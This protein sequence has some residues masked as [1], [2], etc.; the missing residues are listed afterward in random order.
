MA[1]AALC[2]RVIVDELISRGVRDVVLAPGSRS[3]PLAYEVFEADRI[4]LIRLHV[5]VDERAAGFVALGL[6]K[7]S[8]SPVAVVTTS[9]SAVA[10]LHPAVLEAW[11][12]YVPLVAVT[13]SRPRSLIYTGSNQTTDQ[14]QIFGRHVRASAT[15]SDVP[16][17]PRSWRYETARLL[18]AGTGVR[19][20]LP[21][22]VHLNVELSEPLVSGDR[23]TPP[24]A[25]E[26]VV[27]AIGGAQNP[28]RLT[29]GPQTVVVAGDAPPALGAQVAALAARGALPLLAEPSSNARFG[30]HAISTSRL[31]L[32]SSLA[33]EIE[34][35]VVFG[36]PTLS[37]TVTRLLARH[38]VELIVVSDHAEWVD[39]GRAASV[40]ADAVQVAEPGDNDWLVRWQQADAELRGQVDE[41]LGTQRQFTGPHLAAT[42]WKA[43]GPA[44]T[45]FAGSSNAIR[46]LDLAPVAASTPAVF[47]NRGLAGIDGNISTACGIA[48][49]VGRPSH[50]LIGD[51]TA[52]HDMTGLVLGPQEPRPDLRVIVA[53]DDGGSIFATLE[54]GQPAHQRAFE[55]LFG[56]PHGVSFKRVAEAT[57]SA[58]QRVLD[59]PALT[60]VL[61]EPP[62]GIELVEAVIDRTRRRTLDAE[63]NGLA[64]TI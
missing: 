47:A 39:P 1:N 11:H 13:A 31:L 50:A 17:D 59:G 18:T 23:S 46:D 57:G 12:A 34:R 58:Y 51:V 27:A 7:G 40:V 30:K 25:P 49:A 32:G 15:V 14:E 35:V 56:T 22:P 53:N 55:R 10:N 6:A 37:R 61:A 21:G 33:E 8:G 29:P 5:R 36:R 64:A 41:L 63:I 20:R 2:A 9:G 26:L 38:D 45:L 62:L 16:A 4:G 54:P 52:A 24:T 28:L 43:L 44:D 42:L 48:L 19:T 3:A 60:D